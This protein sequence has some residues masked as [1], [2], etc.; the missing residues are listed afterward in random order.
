[1]SNTHLVTDILK[2]PNENNIHD[3]GD[4]EFITFALP[5]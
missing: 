4:V 5:W 1:L 3:N 2:I